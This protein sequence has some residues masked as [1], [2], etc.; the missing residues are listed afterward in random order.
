MSVTNYSES[1]LASVLLAPIV[2]EKATQVAEKHNQVLFKVETPCALPLVLSGIRSAML[3]IVSTA[4]I[5]ARFSVSVAPARPRFPARNS[6][7]CARKRRWFRKTRKAAAF[8][9]ARAPA[10]C[11]RPARKRWRATHIKRLL[12][13]EF[14]TGGNGWPGLIS[15]AEHQAL[16]ARLGASGKPTR[17]REGRRYLLSGLARCDGCGEP[18]QASGGYYRCDPRSGCSVPTKP[19]GV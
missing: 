4:T 10:R 14:H 5:A 2:S 1:R 18:L 13:S 9:P 6:G 12:L 8:S 17:P 3:Q 7:R 16:K 15:E 19:S 11:C